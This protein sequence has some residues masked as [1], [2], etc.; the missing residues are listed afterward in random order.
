M[1]GDRLWDDAGREWRRVAGQWADVAEVE[2]R[3]ADARVV[4]L[5]GFGRPLQWLTPNT[6]THRWE[7]MRPHFEVP[8]QYGARSDDHDLTYA[9]VVWRR[10][11]EQ[12]LGFE[13]FC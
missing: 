7:Q 2:R 9:A 4:L 11:D 12:L 10:G 6:A 13:A 5:H 1:L 8:G 3:L